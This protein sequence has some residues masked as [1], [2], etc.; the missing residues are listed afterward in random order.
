[1]F[2]LYIREVKDGDDPTCRTNDYF[3]SPAGYQSIVPT[4]IWKPAHSPPGTVEGQ[5]EYPSFGLIQIKGG[6]G[7]IPYDYLC[8]K[9]ENDE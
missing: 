7:L 2:I 6:S 5:A 8:Q 4:V 3:L 1:M 9:D